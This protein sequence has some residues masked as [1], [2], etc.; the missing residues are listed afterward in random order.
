MFHNK[1][2]ESIALIWEGGS[3]SSPAWYILLQLRT[4]CGKGIKIFV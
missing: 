2:V 1:C 3:E 4:V